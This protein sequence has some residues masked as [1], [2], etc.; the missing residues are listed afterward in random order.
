MLF[1]WPVLLSTMREVELRRRDFRPGKIVL[2]LI[3]EKA[4]SRDA[5]C[6]LPKYPEIIGVASAVKSERHR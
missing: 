1:P 5:I 6:V 4:C 3:V 2:M